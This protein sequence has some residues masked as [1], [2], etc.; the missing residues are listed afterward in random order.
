MSNGRQYCLYADA[1]YIKGPWLL[2]PFESLKATP[3]RAAFITMMMAASE[4]VEYTYKSIKKI[5][6]SH[7]FRREL[8]VLQAP[9]ALI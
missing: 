4:V 5:A 2:V 3:E 1:A 6:S 7:E 9:V 8:K